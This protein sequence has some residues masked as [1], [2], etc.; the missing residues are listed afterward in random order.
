MKVAK[1]IKILEAM[2]PDGE[3]FLASQPN[4]PFEYTITGVVTR[5]DMLAEGDS[6]DDPTYD[7]GTAPTDV[8]IVEGQQLR[9]GSKL[10]WIAA[11]Q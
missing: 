7:D 1:L 5:E 8:L 2:D 9:Y 3:I 4:W 10:A 6:E 11:R